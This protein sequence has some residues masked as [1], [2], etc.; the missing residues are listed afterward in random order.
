[1]KNLIDFEKEID[2]KFD[3]ENLLKNIFIHRS[4]LNENPS[5][6]LESNERLEFLGDAV[7]ELI[8][9]EHMYQNYKNS[10]GDLTSWRA[11]LV[12]GKNLSDISKKFNMGEYLFLSKGEEKMGGRSRELLM[13]NVFEALVGAMYLEKGY[14]E[15]KKFLLKHLLNKLP[16]VIENKI[17]LDPKTELQEKSQSEQGITPTYEVLG[18][19][20][21]DHN[22]IFTVGVFLNDKKIGEGKGSSKQSGQISAAGDALKKWK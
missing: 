3:D 2:L 7:I 13:A 20:G 15:T 22:K 12:C 11:A 5:T 10:E 6:G 14:D 16:E 18:E 1:M 17:Y 21:P 19:V 9:T 8:V 4:Y